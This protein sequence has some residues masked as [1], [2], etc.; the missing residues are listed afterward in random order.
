[1]ITSL[2]ISNYALI[3][4]LELTPNPS[5][6]IITGET[7]S[8]K[9]II[10]GALSLLQGRRSDAK[11]FGVQLEKSAVEAEFSLTPELAAAVN[12]IIS[13]AGAS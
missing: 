7:G 1:M 4:E 11:T 6:N 9:S 10:M 3:R 8:G 5:F 2:R 13:D 12:A